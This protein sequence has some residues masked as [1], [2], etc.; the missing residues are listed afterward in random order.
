MSPLEIRSFLLGLEKHFPNAESELNYSSHYEL[1]V[2]VVLS[3]Q[4]TDKS[5]NLVTPALFKAAPD[6]QALAGLKEEQIADYIK[7][8]GLWRNKA[9]NLSALGKELSERH[10]G[11]VPDNRKALEA[12]SGVGRKTANVVLNVAFGQNTMAVDTHIFRLGNR[13]GIAKG[14]NVREVEEALLKRIPK[15]LLRPSHHWLIL[16]GRYICKARKPECFH[17]PVREFCHFP[18]K[19]TL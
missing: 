7:T 4:S 8:L 13:T 14:K 18:E 6:A 9:K 16:L 15:D 3:A 2:S 19:T 11:V 10:N 12:L 1:L 5:V 17:C